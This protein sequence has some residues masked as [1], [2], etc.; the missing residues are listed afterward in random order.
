MAYD[1]VCVYVWSCNDVCYT[2]LNFR[3]CVGAVVVIFL[4]TIISNK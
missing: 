2:I 1:Y 3:D 4:V